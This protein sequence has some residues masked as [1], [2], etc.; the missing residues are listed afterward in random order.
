MLKRHAA[1]GTIPLLLLA[2][3]ASPA[4]AQDLRY[5][6]TNH[7]EVGGTAGRFLSALPGGGDPTVETTF[8]KGNRIRRDQGAASSSIMDWDTGILTTLDHASRTFTEVNLLQVAEATAEGGKAMQ[9]GLKD[10]KDAV[11]DGAET[12]AQETEQAYR[13][14]GGDQLGLRVFVE[15]ERTGRTETIQGYTAEQVLVSLEIKGEKDM[16]DW[17]AQDKR[18][19]LA[20]VTE[21]WLSKDFPE[22]QM[23]ADMEGEAL[24]QLQDDGADKGFLGALEYLVTYDPR[25]KFAFEKNRET[26]DAMDGVP[27]RTTM[28]FVNLPDDARLDRDQVLAE[29]DRSLINDATDAAQK[30]AKKAAR[31]AVSGLTGRMFGRKKAPE[32]EPEPEAASQKVFLRFVSEISDV[33]TATLSEDLFEVP[34]NYTQ[35]KGSPET[36]GA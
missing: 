28:H 29:A 10:M 19:G 6:R 1:L 9:G 24:E 2:W 34:A 3:A 22:Y 31:S 27:L 25:V 17:E 26:I 20:I 14:D 30:N 7:M 5:V 32:P 35:A 16:A 18:G 23:M 4:D 21:V 11:A 12:A 8:L 36:S 13:E 33:E 15:S